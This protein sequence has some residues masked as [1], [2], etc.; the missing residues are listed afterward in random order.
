MC[1]DF[2]QAMRKVDP[3]IRLIASG[4]HGVHGKW[5]LSGTQAW[6]E[7][8][9]SLAGNAFDAYSYHEYIEPLDQISRTAVAPLTLTQSGLEGLRATINR[10]APSHRPQTI[11]FDEWNLWDAWNRTPGIQEALSAG[12]TL[13]MLCREANRLGIEGV[14]Y[15]QPVNEG[16]IRVLPTTAELTP[17]G[18][19][20]SL[21]T[22]HAGGLPVKASGNLGTCD[23]FAS[24][25]SDGY[26]LT[27]TTINVGEQSCR[28][29]F[30]IAGASLESV[31]AATA[32]AAKSSVASSDVVG[33]KIKMV[34]ADKTT[35]SAVL[36][37]LSFG[38]VEFRLAK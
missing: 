11:F 37:A 25:S 7:R 1:R 20:F 21:L 30:R 33:S 13:H 16:A 10:L 5:P 34:R 18:R 8:I 3:T 36:P 12:V 31:G 38:Q 4:M 27:V 29:S 19:V 22:A 35:Y 17:V 24:L 15:F 32:Y 14:C 26:S 9:L 2:A 23:V 28:V 6:T